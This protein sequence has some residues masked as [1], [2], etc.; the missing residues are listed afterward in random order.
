LRLHTLQDTISHNDT[1]QETTDFASTASLR[2]TPVIKTTNH[3]PDDQ[4]PTS[5]TDYYLARLP[6]GN[7]S[8][9]PT[10]YPIWQPTGL[11]HDPFHCHSCTI[12][13]SRWSESMQSSLA[14]IDASILEVLSLVL[15]IVYSLFFA[16][17][18]KLLKLFY[19][20]AFIP[21]E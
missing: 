13:Y 9:Y 6:N 12:Q 10:I 17:Y 19:F 8:T 3:L 14:T 11:F 7:P 2:I 16:I 18:P 5:T 4:P 20:V 1:S 15:R 21:Q